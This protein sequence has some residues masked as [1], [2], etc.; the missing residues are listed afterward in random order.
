LPIVGAIALY[1]S[2]TAENPTQVFPA[3][4]MGWGPLA[5]RLLS[6]DWAYKLVESILQRVGS[7]IWVATQ[8]VQ[9]AGYM[10]WVLLACLVVLLFVLMR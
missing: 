10:A 8:V 3:A 9:G 6:L 1:R 2:Q 4:I 5:R 7:A